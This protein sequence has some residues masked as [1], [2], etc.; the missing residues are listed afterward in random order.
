MKEKLGT[1]RE[2]SLI[3]DQCIPAGQQRACVRG[4][5]HQDTGKYLGQ[6]CLGRDLATSTLSLDRFL[7]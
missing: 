3:K 5:G 2:G 6:R 4:S 7:G 1:E